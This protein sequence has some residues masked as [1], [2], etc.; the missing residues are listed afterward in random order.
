MADDSSPASNKGKPPRAEKAARQ[1]ATRFK[2]KSFFDKI[3][4]A[5]EA[6][7]LAKGVKE[8]SDELGQ[9]SKWVRC[10][11][12]PADHVNREKA[13][14]DL[15]TELVASAAAF[16][17]KICKTLVENITPQS[18]AAFNNTTPLEPLGDSLVANAANFD[19]AP[20][21]SLMVSMRDSPRA[22]FKKT[23]TAAF[24]ILA[25]QLRMIGLPLVFIP[26]LAYFLEGYTASDCT[27]GVV[28][29]KSNGDDNAEAD[30][31]EPTKPQEP[32]K[33][34]S[35]VACRELAAV[36]A[37]GILALLEKGEKTYRGTCLVDAGT[38]LLGCFFYHFSIH[39]I[40][41]D[42]PNLPPQSVAWY[43]GEETLKSQ[44]THEALT[45]LITKLR[46]K[47]LS[48][49]AAEA[50]LATKKRYE[51]IQESYSP[52]FDK[53]PNMLKKTK[54]RNKSRTQPGEEEPGPSDAPAEPVSAPTEVLAQTKVPAPTEAPGA[55]AEDAGGPTDAL[56]ASAEPVPPQTEAPA[57][58]LAKK[59][60]APEA[61]TRRLSK[62]ARQYQQEE[63]A[64][65]T[66]Q[67]HNDIASQNGLLLDE[68]E[69][70]QR[71]NERL[72]GENHT[73]R[74]NDALQELKTQNEILDRQVEYTVAE[75]RRLNS[76]QDDM[77]KHSREIVQ[78]NHFSI[79][80][81][82]RDAFRGTFTS[83]T[84]NT[85]GGSLE[86]EAGSTSTGTESKTPGGE[87]PAPT[88]MESD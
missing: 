61:G 67:F 19:A 76:L 47:L 48:T 21:E 50:D 25:R 36:L 49:I 2:I 52:I 69:R 38:R 84:T 22:Y 42:F 75:I 7:P 33:L 83:R 73:L 26:S 79:R 77:L 82:I 40:R 29:D 70:L 16:A 59:R 41:S 44:M 3:A 35:Q 87:G 65:R 78:T 17:T 10:V 14:K 4:N 54:P 11:F 86:V 32:D 34:P 85:G 8:V 37:L 27:L 28:L 62:K 39:E 68:N 13:T 51:K 63:E 81:W 24:G 55:P 74:S 1:A 57:Q 9:V 88:S 18:L 6:E 80:K 20:L 66:E 64:M 60:R 23:N 5:W 45:N 31:Q 71:E 30:K 72:K 56:V 58:P 43:N 12:T 53:L 46:E 15:S